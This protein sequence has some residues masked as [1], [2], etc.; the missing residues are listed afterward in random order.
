MPN[1]SYIARNMSGEKITGSMAAATERDVVNTLTGKSLFPIS[2]ATEKSS[3]AVTLGGKVST[4]KVATFYDQLASLL[5]NGVPLLKSI[6]ILR[7]QA[8]SQAMQNA[9]DDVISKV[10]DGQ[11][12]GE[13]FSRHPKI[14]NEMAVNMTKAGAEGGFL[15]DALERVAAFTEQQSELRS[16]TVGALIYPAVLLMAGSTVVSL[17]LVFVVPRFDPMF[18]ALRQKNELPAQT[19]ILLNFSKWLASYWWVMLTVFAVLFVAI[20]V[21]LNTPKGKILS[22]T[23]KLKTPMFGVIFQNLAIARFCRVLGTLLKN[24]VPMIR[25][26]DISR[27]A[28]GNHVLSKAIASATENI[29][30]GATLST[31][32]AKSGRFPRNVTEMIAVA[33]ESNTMDTVLVNIAQG[34]E[35]ETTRRL[36]LM[37]KLIE[38]LLLTIMAGVILF[39]VMAL[40]LPIMNMSNALRE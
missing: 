9:L 6:S 29:T 14:F 27:E 20:R 11:G 38:P 26:L 8:S 2:I 22:D 31:P 28:V 23:L 7:Q 35:K 10:E 32:L 37:V 30:S 24:G 1:Y 4:Q 12:L 3:A 17:L 39:V 36:D 13:A 19:E 33:E 18:D 34:L 21:Q 16:R 25:S 40:L 15:E 5:K